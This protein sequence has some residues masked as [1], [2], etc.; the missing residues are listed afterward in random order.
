[1]AQILRWLKVEVSLGLVDSPEWKNFPPCGD[2]PSHR[3]WRDEPLWTTVVD[4]LVCE[5]ISSRDW[6]VADWNGVWG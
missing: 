1:M 3:A 2:M 6:E 4:V 5:C